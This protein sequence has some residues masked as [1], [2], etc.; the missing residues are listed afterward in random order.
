LHR[1]NWHAAVGHFQA[2]ADGAP[3]TVIGSIHE[4]VGL[5][6]FISL[7]IAAEVLTRAFGKHPGWR[8]FQRLSGVLALV[9]L[10]GFRLYSQPTQLTHWTDCSVLHN[11]LWQF[12]VAVRA[13]QRAGGGVAHVATVERASV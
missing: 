3:D 9:M 4:N 10:C 1:R 8:S 13:S 11:I 2:G 6:T 12:V 5:C 7:L